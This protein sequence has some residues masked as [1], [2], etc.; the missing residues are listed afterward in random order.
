MYDRRTPGLFKVEAEG[1]EMVELCSKTYILK[2]DDDDEQELS[3][4]GVNT[5]ENGSDVFMQVL[6]D[7]QPVVATNR[8]FRL[9]NQVKT[10][11]N[12]SYCKRIVLEDG[13][14]TVPL[15]VVLC[16]WKKEEE[17]EVPCK[18]RKIQE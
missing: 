3:C 8:G 7:R 2:G 13:I 6:Q 12:Y 14:H 4:K 18:K 5:V 16:P 1:K 10:A 15:D 17:E 9:D 11:I